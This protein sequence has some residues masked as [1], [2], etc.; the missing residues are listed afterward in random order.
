MIGFSLVRKSRAQKKARS[1][2]SPGDEKE[3]IY[4]E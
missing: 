1:S 2:R 3:M 4:A